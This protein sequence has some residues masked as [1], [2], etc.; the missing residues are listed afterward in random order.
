MCFFFLSL[1]IP[2]NTTVK[3][4]TGHNTE[5][6]LTDV[7]DGRSRPGFVLHHSVQRRQSHLSDKKTTHF[8]H[9]SYNRHFY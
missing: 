1:R 4:H 2:L 8:T 3:T 6:E 7:T 9:K 5:I